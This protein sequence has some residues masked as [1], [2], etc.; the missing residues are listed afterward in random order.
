MA[1]SSQSSRIRRPVET[2]D[3][4]RIVPER[5]LLDHLSLG[6]DVAGLVVLYIVVGKDVLE[7]VRI[8]GD[9]CTIAVFK[10]LQDLLFVVQ[11]S[12]LI[13]ALSF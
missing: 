11:Q 9:D 1:T 13:H 8:G 2:I 5:K 12:I 3:T 10:E 7:F 6:R 4:N